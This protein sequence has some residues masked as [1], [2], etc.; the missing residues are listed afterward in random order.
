MIQ[1]IEL[2]DGGTLEYAPDFY[3]K[4][5]ADRFLATL[6]HEIPW[7]QESGRFGPFPRLTAWCADAGLTYSYS[8]VT[9]A[10][11]AWTGTLL[12]IRHEVEQAAG[13][14]FNS[15]LLNFYRDGQ[16]SMGYHADD[17]AELGVNPVIASVSFG[18]ERRFLLKHRRTRETMR[19]DLAHGSLLVMGGTCQH[20]WLHAVPKTKTVP[21]ERINLTFRTIHGVA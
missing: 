1:H 20:H 4:E 14:T 18:A 3:A 12:A 9:H 11:L 15:L 2:R 6:R 7:R 8:G 5:A 13:T 17:E 16:D 21:G 10:P 19:F